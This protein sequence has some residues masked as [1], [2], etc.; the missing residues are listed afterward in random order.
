MSGEQTLNQKS[1]GWAVFVPSL[2]CTEEANVVFRGTHSF[3]TQL[4]SQPQESFIWNELHQK[5]NQF[6]WAQ[7]NTAF[8]ALANEKVA[9][10]T[11]RCCTYRFNLK[12][13]LWI[14]PNIDL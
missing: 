11:E 5:S 14:H 13:K 9:L 10:H 3:P 1:S 6:D 4:Y 8:T 2:H 7:E 12:E